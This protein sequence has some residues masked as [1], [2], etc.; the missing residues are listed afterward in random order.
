MDAQADTPVVAHVNYLFFHSTQ[1]YIHFYLR[2]F[3][4]T[5]PLCLT[6]TPESPLIDASI[7]P[8]LAGNFYQYGASD[9]AGRRAGRI[10]YALGLAVRRRLARMPPR[11][12]DPILQALHRR[13]VP[14]LRREADGGRYLAWAGDILERRR[15]RL[16]HAYYGPVGWRMLALKRRLGVP[17]V[18]T[19]LGDDVAPRV[20]D[21]WSW[22]IAERSEPPEWP[23]R[24]RELLAGADLFLT[25]GPVLRQRLIDLGCP[26]ERIALQRIA[27]PVAEMPFRARAPRPGMPPII[28]FAGRFAEQ[29]GLVYALDAARALRQEGREFELRIVGDETLTDG[30]YASRIYA[31]VRRHRLG[32]RVRMLGFLNRR[33]YIREME[34]ADIF[35]HPSVT[36]DNGATEG[37]APTTILEAQALGLPVVST[38]HCDIPNVTLPDRSALLVPERQSADLA[39]ALGWLL[40]HGDRWAEMGRAGRA[41]MELHH[42]AD[43]EAP[44]LEARYLGLLNEARTP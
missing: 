21:W 17:L 23:A 8:E 13:I 26:P 15:A 36:A 16:I 24:L 12:S 38:Y 30:T 31:D 27:V 1:S 44:A 7:A 3:R 28:L 29:K 22:W 39:R 43:R 34:R 41:H 40:N 42:D 37:G 11:L 9:A 6:R 35:L 32:D 5:R 25:E 2:R 19:F 33:D 20:S 18:V 14:R 4:A 10:V